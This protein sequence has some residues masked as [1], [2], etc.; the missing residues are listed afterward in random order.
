MVARQPVSPAYVHCM[1]D[2]ERGT[3]QEGSFRR[4]REQDRVNH[5]YDF[6]LEGLCCLLCPVEQVFKKFPDH[7]TDQSDTR[8]DLNSGD[9]FS[10]MNIM[11]DEMR[12]GFFGVWS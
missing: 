3:G 4:N 7:C 6:C 8:E 11:S 2:V 10:S 12:C 9:P 1:H 5:S